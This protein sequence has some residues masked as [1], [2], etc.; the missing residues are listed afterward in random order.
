MF[1]SIILSIFCIL[2]IN[3][4]ANHPGVTR[5]NEY[6]KVKDYKG[7]FK[8]FSEVLLSDAKNKEALYGKSYSLYKMKKYQES[9]DSFEILL[10]LD[11]NYKDS[12]YRTAFLYRKVKKYEKAI[13]YYKQYLKKVK[14]DPDSFYGLA[15]TNEQKRDKVY[16]AYNYYKYTIFEKRPSEEKWI[17]KAQDKIKSYKQEF[18]PEELKKYE[19]LI[20]AE[21]KVVAL[22]VKK[23]NKDI[24]KETL[25]VKAKV[26]VKKDILDIPKKEVSKNKKETS[27]DKNL[28]YMF[29]KGVKGDDLYLSQKYN[30]AIIAYRAYLKD[31]T[32]RREGLY[33][34]AISNAMLKKYPTSVKLLSQIIVEEDNDNNVKGILKLLLRNKTVISSLKGATITH[35]TKIGMGKV[36]ELIGRGDY[37]EAIK[38]LDI[39]IANIRN[40]GNA[41]LYKIDLLRILSKTKE[42]DENLKSFL[43]KNPDNIIVNEK[44]GD[45]LFSQ[46]KKEEALNYYKLAMSKTNDKE[47]KARIKSKIS[48]WTKKYDEKNYYPYTYS[49]SKP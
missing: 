26:E 44:Y 48:K 9:I 45:F 37:Y 15:K 13:S 12:L 32:K 19:N 39:L 17:K 16:A 27:M 20:K 22:P 29:M 5:G 2:S 18:S 46:N 40:N 3:I 21:T 10:L 34:M 28:N 36:N 42:I 8:S 4:M 25:K 35:K 33:K 38:I 31:P 1:K 24:T 30:D 11:K 43:L 49:N 41:L 14:N 47:I 7:S 6:L 23:V